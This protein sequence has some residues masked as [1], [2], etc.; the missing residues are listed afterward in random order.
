M[1]S[2][3]YTQYIYSQ[4]MNLHLLT[5][6]LMGKKKCDKFDV[7]LQKLCDNW[8]KVIYC[9]CIKLQMCYKSY[10]FRFCSP[11]EFVCGMLVSFLRWW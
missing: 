3:L 9:F 1:L 6:S 2:I 10:V 4:Y 7:V 8:M 11:W 5:F